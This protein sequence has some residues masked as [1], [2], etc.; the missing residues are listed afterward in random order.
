RTQRIRAAADITDFASIH[1]GSWCWPGIAALS[2]LQSQHA[3][4]SGSIHRNQFD[5]SSNQR[6][7]CQVDL[8][9]C[10]CT[11]ATPDEGRA[12]QPRLWSAAAVMRALKNTRGKNDHL[13]SVHCIRST[14]FL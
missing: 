6:T 14:P 7:P 8:D 10:T 1:L 5:K 2:R 9:S 13:E 4:P 12:T 3:Q 11:V